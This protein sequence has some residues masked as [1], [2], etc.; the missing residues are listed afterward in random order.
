MTEFGISIEDGSSYLSSSSSKE[1]NKV[2]SLRDWQRR[3]ID[4]FFNK[5]EGKAIFECAT[6]VGKTFFAI[7]II[8]RILK[9]NPEYKILIVVPKNVI[10]ETGWYK[11]LYEAGVS[12]KDIGVYY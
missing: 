2:A 9:E 8:K 1:N 10:M 5:S 7:E 4:F 12:I 3:G 6:G 11:E